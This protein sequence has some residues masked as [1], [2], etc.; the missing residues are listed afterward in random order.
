MGWDR[1]YCDGLTVIIRLELI[2]LFFEN[3]GPEFFTYPFHYIQILPKTLRTA[4]GIPGRPRPDS[5]SFPRSGD[6]VSSVPLTQPSAY[7]FTDGIEVELRDEGLVVRTDLIH[8][9]IME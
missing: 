5:E 6:E 1:R 3:L 8:E 4:R 7:T 9:F 2:N